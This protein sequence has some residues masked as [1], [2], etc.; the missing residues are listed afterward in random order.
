M[1]A[2]TKSEAPQKAPEEGDWL[3]RLL[4]DVREEVVSQPSPKAVHR[5]RARLFAGIEAPEKAAA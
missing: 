2:A 4:A 1:K 5:I 3:L